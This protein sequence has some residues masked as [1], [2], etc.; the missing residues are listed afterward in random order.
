MTNRKLIAGIT[1]LTTGTIINLVI[2]ILGVICV[3]K[4]TVY[5]KSLGYLW[6]TIYDMKLFVPL[7]IGSILMLLGIT[8][9]LIGAF[10]KNIKN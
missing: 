4:T 2:L 9:T 1:F 10:T 6:Q 5:Q 8:L 7:V 3:E